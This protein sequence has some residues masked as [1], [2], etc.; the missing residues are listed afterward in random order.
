MK[1]KTKLV[2]IEDTNYQIGRFA[3]DVGSWIIG[4]TL[5]AGM[6]DAI[7]KMKMLGEDVRQTTPQPVEQPAEPD[8]IEFKI[9]RTMTSA[10]SAMTLEERSIIQRKCL[11]K[12]SR[13]EGPESNTPM[14]LSNGNGVIRGD[15]ADDLRLVL[16]LEMEVLIFNF[17]DF[18]EQGG[19][20][21]LLQTPAPRT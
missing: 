3:A 12:C 9:R 5:N 16:Q 2:T 20:N 4:C 21:A 10:F 17:F 15:I 14:P 18:F 6:R 7:G 19:F 8:D 11:E 13:M 1:E